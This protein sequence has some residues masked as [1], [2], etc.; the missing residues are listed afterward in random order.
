[1]KFP[2]TRL[3]VLPLVVVIAAAEIMPDS[4][5]KPVDNPLKAG[6]RQKEA[7]PPQPEVP[8]EG[9]QPPPPHIARPADSET[10]L[11]DC[12][13]QLDA[14]GVIYNRAGPVE[15]ENGCGI[16]VPYTMSQIA[17]GIVVTPD[18]RLRCATVLAAAKWVRD[19]V[20]P[21]ARALPGDAKLK[22]VLI[23]TTYQCRRRNNSPTGKISE[24]AIGNA[25]DVS[26]FE[27][28]GRPSIGI[29]PRAGT[30]TIE[31]AFQRSV[32]AGACL[33]FTTVL[34]PGEA[35]HDDHLHLDIAVRRGGYRL[36]Q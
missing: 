13:K 10:E 16:D 7:V 31:E 12:E 23:G 29:V 14:L 5:P 26:G 21:A 30:G 2:V 33:H 35:N 4:V 22:A 24:H 15:G 32:R 27:F 20:E 11:T 28:D 8:Q 6:E 1:M 19:E 9:E 36:C 17:P 18:T 34:G 25:I 3:F